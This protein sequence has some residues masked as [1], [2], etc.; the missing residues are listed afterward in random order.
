MLKSYFYYFLV[1]N[2]YKEIEQNILFFVLIMRIS[3]CFNFFDY[4]I[5]FKYKYILYI[6][7]TLR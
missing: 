2:V 3:P 4:L 1:H 6:L 5:C 7:Y